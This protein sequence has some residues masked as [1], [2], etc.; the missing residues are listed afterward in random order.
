MRVAPTSQQLKR[1]RGEHIALLFPALLPILIF[2]VGPLLRGMY[3]GFTGYQ[4]GDDAAVFNGLANYRHM[5]GDRYFWQSLWT[6]LIWAVVVTG[7]QVGL[8]LGLALLLNANLRLRW[9][10]RTL[11]LVPWAMP[12]VIKG[13][14][15]RLVYHPDAG[16]LNHLLLNLG[17][18]ERPVNWL[19]DFTWTLPAVLLVG[20]WAGMPQSAITLLAGLQTIPEEL[21]EAAAIDGADGW[22][23]FWHVTRPLLRPVMVAIISLEFIWNFNSFSLVYVL[24]E[25]GPGGK[26]RLPMLLAYEEAF[27]YGNFGYAAALGNAMMVIIT[28]LVFI[29]FRNQLREQQ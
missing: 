2:S 28:L 18:L 21:Y 24:T 29:Y 12:P 11:V 22:Q 17:I 20:I 26:T 19:S 25:G 16:I 10:A 9:L 15:W 8:G 7:G 6:G 23:K 5:L 13:L 27:R 3:M 1:L 4:L 14:M